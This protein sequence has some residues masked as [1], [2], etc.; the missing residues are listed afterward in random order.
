MIKLTLPDGGILEVENGATVLDAAGQISRSLAKIA[1]CGVSD[2][3]MVDL[4]TALT[5]DT[6]LRIVTEKDPEA[7][8]V[9]RHTTAHIMAQAVKRL[10]SPVAVAIGPAIDNGFYY[11]FDLDHTFSDEDLAAIEKEMRNII[12]ENIP[13][14]RRILSAREAQDYFHEKKE[15]YKEELLRDIPPE[16]PISLY[17]QGDFSDLCRGP[18]LPATGRVKHFR[19]LSVAGAY[20]RGDEKNKMLQRIYGTAFFSGEALDEHIRALEE[21]RMRDHRKL[22]K[23]MGLFHIEPEFGPGLVYWLPKGAFIR[24]KLEDYL[25]DELIRSGYSIVNTPHI[26]KSDLWKTSGHWNF[27]RENMF[28]PITI[29]EEEYLLKPMN[30]P[31][32]VLIFKNETRSYRDLPV[33]TAEFGTVY[34]YERSGVL[35]G[36]MRVRGFTQDDAHIFCRPDQLHQEIMDLIAFTKRVLHVFGFEKFDVYLSTRPEKY[37]GEL[38]QWDIATRAL[39]EALKDTGLD[40][41]VD[42]GEGVFYGPKIDIKIRDSLNR[43]WQ[44]T[45]I[46]VD[47]NLPQRFDIHYIGDDGEPHRPIMIHRALLG[48]LERFFGV[49]IEHYAGAFPAWLL[50][51]HAKILPIADRHLDYAG[52]IKDALLN[53]GVYAD[54]DSRNE[55]VGKK[56]RDA[57]I[58]EKVPYMLI[59]GD[60][61][62]EEEKTVSVRSRA[63]EDLGAFTLDDFARLVLDD[64]RLKR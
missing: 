61:E 15:P 34:R 5:R 7:L 26:S 33:K 19:L 32:H 9:L 21:A 30:C 50:P 38:E 36:L 11:D 62:E 55:K 22:G 10:F 54:I 3:K 24:R 60:K 2:G 63:G 14:T 16:E 28:S 46:Q 13:I 53:S 58:T 1:V 20:W 31:F 52:R 8:E 25:I 43:S 6:S 12:K 64:I 48:S 47:F 44:C 29:D 35:H 18:H 51:V 37:V 17:E 59:I 49:L 39:E 42:P 27:Y 45:T 57:Q 41:T 4:S 40:Y 23:Q 56:I